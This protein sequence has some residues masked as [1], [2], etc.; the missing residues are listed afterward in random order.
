MDNV[1]CSGLEKILVN[2]SYTTPYL[3]YHNEDI[4]VRCSPREL[5][6]YKSYSHTYF[7]PLRPIAALAAI[8]DS[9]YSRRHKK[10]KKCSRKVK[11]SLFAKDDF[12]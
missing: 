10:C 12:T 11:S 7:N 1:Y 8:I 3:D 5:H 2:C 4:G 9:T 6:T